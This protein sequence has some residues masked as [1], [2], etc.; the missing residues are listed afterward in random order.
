[1]AAVVAAVWFVLH[2]AVNVIYADQWRDVYLLDQAALGHLTVGDVWAQYLEHRVVVPDLLLLSVGRLTR[3]NLVVTD[4]L[5]AILA[6][7]AA[8]TLLW[9][10]RRWMP[11]LPWVVL[12]P[13]LLLVLSPVPM[14]DNVFGFNI[15]WYLALAGFGL[16]V[17]AADGR[18]GR[19]G[20]LAL[21]AVAATVA[22][23]SSF[24]GLFV[25]P[26]VG[27]VLV[28]R[29]RSLRQQLGWWAAAV[30]VLTAFFI[31][32]RPSGGGHVSAGYLFG[33]P[34]AALGYFVSQFGVVTGD[35]MGHA[36]S[37]PYTWPLAVAGGAV[38]VLALVGLGSAVRSGRHDGSPVAVAMVV[39]ALLFAVTSTV[40][41]VD[42]GID[43]AFLFGPFA[44][45]LWAGAYLLWVAKALRPVSPGR[46]RAGWASRGPAVGA[47]AAVL[48]V[49]IAWMSSTVEGT[50]YERS[51][52][53]LEL[54]WASL[55]AN[56][57]QVP[58]GLLA[59]NV[60]P[61]VSPTFIAQMAEVAR[62]R[63]LSLFATGLAAQERRR[64]VDPALV[65]TV[66]RPRPGV[67]PSGP[68]L[69]DAAVY[70]P[71]QRVE[72]TI[73]DGA[74]DVLVVGAQRW[75]YG[76]IA[77]W[78]PTGPGVVAIRA[79]AVTGPGRTYTSTAVAVQV[80]PAP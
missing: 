6:C 79:V 43:H 56:A 40:G 53:T 11:R 36:L 21:A 17:V 2:Y 68:V 18:H 62:R 7:V 63:R 12:L 45:L 19:S 28:L 51:Y 24:P 15:C 69:L 10:F 55:E 57:D 13:P 42:Q 54:R 25:W 58:P 80:R 20:H 77:S 46:F 3:D 37:A 27:A 22:S 4:G 61:G 39:V 48:L 76:W 74:G 9:S 71:A 41:R 26:A 59:T 32:Y 34:A 33:H 49:M 35:G 64:G 14:S 31:G 47:V 16:A 29:G 8:L 52:H 67:V 60:A 73:R 75:T 1:M 70:L 44:V 50:G 23:F 5:S 30:V 38:L 65:V 78:R 66:E 72:F